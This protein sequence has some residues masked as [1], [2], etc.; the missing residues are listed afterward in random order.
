M[1]GHDLRRTGRIGE[2]I[3]EFRT[4]HEL[5]TRPA[6]AAEVPPPYDWH[7]QHNLDLLATSHQYI[8][9]V[10]TAEQLMRRSFEIRSPLVIQE[11]NKH[12]WPAFLLARGRPGEAL[13]AAQLLKASP[14]PIVR[15]IGHVMAGRALLAM[16][17]FAEAADASNLAL[18]ELRGAGPEASLA[19]PHLQGLQAE[20]LLRTGHREKAVAAFRDVRRKI[21]ALPGP[22][23]WSQGLFRLESIGRA[24]VATG[25]WELATETAADMLA[26]DPSYGGTHYLAALVAD[27]SGNRA[28]MMR[29]LKRAAEAWREADDDFADLKDVQKRLRAPAR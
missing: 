11:F 22:D 18:K 25:A 23:A 10:R 5:E 17:R 16:E 20:F 6:R 19:A 26:H 12:E 2:A 1:L 27:R 29:H 13:A 21:R 15:G 7:H 3:A 4:A 24:A 8:G 14:A 28:G 9:Q